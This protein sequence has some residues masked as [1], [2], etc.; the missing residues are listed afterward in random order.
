MSWTF[1]LIWELPGFS[2][3]FFQKQSGR[4]QWSGLRPPEDQLYHQEGDADHDRQFDEKGNRS[5]DEAECRIGDDRS[6]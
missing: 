1:Q 2:A 4:R 3:S 6:E 5:D